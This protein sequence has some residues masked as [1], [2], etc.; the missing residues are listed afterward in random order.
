MSGEMKGCGC[1]LYKKVKNTEM[2]CRQRDGFELDKFEFFDW[3]AE[4]EKETNAPDPRIA[5]VPKERA[6]TEKGELTLREFLE[7]EADAVNG[8][9]DAEADAV[10]GFRDAEAEGIGIPGI[11]MEEAE[12]AA[13]RIAEA[14]WKA[15][16]IVMDEEN[17]REVDPVYAQRIE[18]KIRQQVRK[19]KKK[20]GVTLDQNRTLTTAQRIEHLEEELIDGL[21]YCEHLTEAVGDPGWTANDYQRAALRTAQMDN[22]SNEEVLLNGVMGLNGEAGEVIDLVKKA[23]FQGHELDTEKLMKELGDIAWYLAV[24]AISIGYSLSD[25]FDANIEKLQK[26]YPDG[27]DKA[28]SMNRAE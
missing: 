8:F 2:P 13:E 9:Q 15:G 14:A 28:R 19:G 27:F 26:R 4:E 22:F 23:R 1:C 16:E 3:K 11:T 25:V 10:N 6:E 12:K 21:M 24:T 5:E 17:K 20:Y 18:E 7:A